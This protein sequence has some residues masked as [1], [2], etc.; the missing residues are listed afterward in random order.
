MRLATYERIHRM[1][2]GGAE[3]ALSFG[4]KLG[5]MAV[6]HPSLSRR[7]LLQA[8]TGAIGAVAFSSVGYGIGDAQAARTRSAA[9]RAGSTATST[10]APAPPTYVSE[11]ALEPPTVTVTTKAKG[12]APGLI[13]T[14]ANIATTQHGPLVI[15]DD[16]SPVWFR[17]LTSG[18]AAFD[19][20][21]QTYQGQPVLT[22]WEGAIDPTAG[23]GRGTYLIADTSYRIIGRVQAAAGLF[24]DLHDFTITDRD[25]ALI[26][27]YHPTSADLTAVGG[28]ASAPLLDSGLQEIDI[29]TGKVLLEWLGSSHLDLSESYEPLPKTAGT[30]WDFL[31][32]NSISVDTDGNLLLSARHTWAVYKIDRTTGEVM[33]RLGGKRSDF[34]IGEGAEF[35]WQHHVVSRG[36]DTISVFDNGSGTVQ[37]EPQSRGMVVALDHK[38]NTA[39]LRKAFAHPGGN[40]LSAASQGSMEVLSDGG[41]F[42]GWG[43]LPNLTEFA[44]DGSVR[45]DAAFPTGGSTYR[46]YRVPWSARPHTSPSVVAQTDSDTTTVYVSWNGATDVERWQL[47]GGSDDDQIAPITNAVRSGFETAM[48]VDNAP[49][50]VAVAGLDHAGHELGRSR[51]VRT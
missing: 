2:P 43:Q 28:T 24:G 32:A 4:T 15:D 5:V 41:A 9:P 7:R 50:F 11:P 13:L 44:P 48:K 22:W 51:A 31:H 8:G 47:L 37:T 27:V 20:R 29:A 36:T 14:T 38:T 19:L 35:S 25:T 45:F 39:R 46:A 40:G 10:D 30:P 17:P 16:G 33:W 26:T 18:T 42:V 12:T 49:A 34:T 23:W 1:L 3:H 6:H 21:A